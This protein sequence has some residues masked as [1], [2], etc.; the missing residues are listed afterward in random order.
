MIISRFFT[1]VED[2]I[3]S[4]NFK[5][6]NVAIDSVKQKSLIYAKQSLEIPIDSESIEN[7]AKNAHVPY[8][9]C[10]LTPHGC[11]SLRIKQFI[12]DTID[13]NVRHCKNVK[14]RFAK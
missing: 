3:D 11:I 2:K 4:I 14:T 10:I 12:S 6:K 7:R 1:T 9:L 8:S 5:L 13:L